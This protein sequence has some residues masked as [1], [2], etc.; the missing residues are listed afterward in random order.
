M[1][2]A[3]GEF[4]RCRVVDVID[5]DAATL[6]FI[7]SGFTASYPQN[8]LR[9]IPESNFFYSL[10]PMCMQFYVAGIMIDVDVPNYRD[11]IKNKINNF[12]RNKI[13]SL[14]VAGEVHF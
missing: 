9:L 5:N 11:K 8:L 10:P 7:D 12:L 6:Y 4:H 2:K 14:T 1:V 3:E 13:V